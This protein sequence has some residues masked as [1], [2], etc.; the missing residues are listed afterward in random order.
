[1]YVSCL[2]DTYCYILAAKT[3][4]PEGSRNVVS[5][6]EVAV[7]GTAEVLIPALTAEA[8][9]RVVL[10]AVEEIVIALITLRSWMNDT[11]VGE[12][13]CCCWTTESIGWPLRRRAYHAHSMVASSHGWRSK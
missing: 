5:I 9:I 7:R 10:G 11:W 8:L 13:A 1:M 3:R 4:Q 6:L 2:G 12:T